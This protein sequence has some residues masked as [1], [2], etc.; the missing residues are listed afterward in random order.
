MRGPPLAHPAGAAHAAPE[1]G[2][3]VCRAQVAAGVAPG[4]FTGA[5]D[6]G[7]RRARARVSA[8]TSASAA[9]GAK[10]I[11]KGAP[12]SA[13]ATPKAALKANARPDARARTIRAA[14]APSCGSRK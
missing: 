4:D 8:A 2:A 12:P 13:T 3:L 11:A 10:S 6:L 1:R 14:Q 7:D 5:A 9:S